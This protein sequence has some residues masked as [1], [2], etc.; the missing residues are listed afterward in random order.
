[1]RNFSL[2]DT[3]W[4]N[5]GHELDAIAQ[6]VSDEK[7]KILLI[8]KAYEI[9][10]FLKDNRA[11]PVYGAITED[12]W[13][14]RDI[15]Q[16]E[17]EE[18]FRNGKEYIC[19]CVA[20]DR[21]EY[22]RIKG[23]VTRFDP[24]FTENVNFFQGEVFQAVYYVYKR[25]E[26]R[27]D[28][29]EIFLTPCCTLN[30]EKCIAFIPYFKDRK[31]TSLE[32]LTQDADLLFSRVDYVFKLKLLGGEGFL[33]PHLVKYIDYLYDHYAEK[34]GEVRIGTN[35]TIF[36]DSDIKECCRRHDV[37]V[38][39]SDYTAAVP[40]RCR[41]SEM[42]SILKEE[43]IRYD[44]KRVGEQWLDMGFPNHIPERRNAEELRSHFQKCAMFCREFYDGKFYFCCSN[45]A[46]VL[47]GLF[48]ENENDYF[49]FRHDF[50]KKELLEYELGYSKLGHTTFCKMCFGCSEEANSRHV[51]VARQMP[52][53]K[54]ETG[55][56]KSGGGSENGGNRQ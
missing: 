51:E 30:C 11:I 8:G 23:K 25:D 46:A 44:V 20:R 10:G 55:E 35:G 2:K 53:C 43:G 21:N 52:P 47:T 48:P 15:K 38:D 34:I 17:M 5:P 18:L 36:P 42:I 32:M 29:I 4:R 33:Y 1:M 19:V 7:K 40:E 54:N 39:I 49:D 16:L 41:L 45:F 56:K 6:Y 27:I 37:I 31:P 28:R 13:D 12:K 50:N 26:I 3:I 14:R 22:D 24:E 9:D